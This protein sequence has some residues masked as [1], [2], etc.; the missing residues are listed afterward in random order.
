MEQMVS[1]K[2]GGE[3]IA[4]KT[5]SDKYY[6]N[7]LVISNSF[8][9][10]I[11]SDLLKMVSL[12][13]TLDQYLEILTTMPTISYKRFNKFEYA[14]VVKALQTIIESKRIKLRGCNK[15]KEAIA[16]LHQEIKFSPN[17]IQNMLTL[18]N[19]KLEIS[20]ILKASHKVFLERPQ[21]KWLQN[22]GGASLC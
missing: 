1:I 7:R 18:F 9:K 10:F 11:F 20:K 17:L 12:G 13:K 15:Q 14:N 22:I 21:P 4:N 2:S 19:V 3:D 5:H 16:F 6:S 8:E